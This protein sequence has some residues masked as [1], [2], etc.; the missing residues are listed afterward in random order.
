MDPTVKLERAPIPD[1][2]GEHAEELAFLGHVR[3]ILTSQPEVRLATLEG[4]DERIAAHLEGLTVAG[5]EGWLAVQAVSAHPGGLFAV[6]LVALETG[7]E[8]KVDQALAVAE[9]VPTIATFV[10][11]GFGWQAKSRLSQTVASLLSHSSA[12][13]REIGIAACAMHRVDPGEALQRTLHDGAPSVRARSLRALGELGRRDLL[14][15]ARQGFDDHALEC[16]FWAAWAAVILSDRDA[17][18]ERLV[19]MSRVPGP[20]RDRAAQLALRATDVGSAHAL[21]RDIVIHGSD[22]RLAIRGAGMTGDASYVTGLIRQMDIIEF[23]RIAGE[24][25]SFITGVDL[26]LA[27]LVRD[28]PGT[29]E[30]GPTEDPADSNVE[31]HPDEGLPWPDGERC[32]AWWRVNAGRFHKG[33]RYFMGEPPSVPH[34]RKVLREGFQRER[35]AAAEHLCL[36]QPGTPLFN[37]AAPTWRQQRSLSKMM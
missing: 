22:M 18:L 7:T 11:A 29:F 13:R 37:V 17:G 9:A 4:F 31:M 14:G 36:L 27:G 25:F 1:I 10:R 28:R 35:I 32:A 8:V 34:C 15:F 20:Y 26:E 5:E 16:R 6:T 12:S 2:I 23:A 3:R 19:E 21:L 24:A 33:V 30:S